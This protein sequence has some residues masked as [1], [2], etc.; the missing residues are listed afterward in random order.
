MMLLTSSCAL[1]RKHVL[2]PAEVRPALEAT[3]DQLLA[4]YNRQANAIRSVNVAVVFT[5]TTGS[6][7]SGVIEEYHEVNGFILARK[8]AQIRVIGQAPVVAKDVFDMTSDGDTFR[9]FIPSQ[10]KFIVGSTTLE[11]SAKKP[12]ENLRPQHLLDVLFWPEIPAGAPS[13]FEEWED[14]AKRFYILTALRQTAGE[15]E[16]ARKIWF[17]RTDLE[18]ARVQIFA[19]GGRVASDIRYAEWALAGEANFPR[20]IWLARPHE[21]YRLEIRITKVEVNEMIADDRFRLEQPPGTELVRAN[22]SSE[23]ARP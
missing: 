23:G 17:D 2:P 9:V 22:E 15:W 10:H 8:P 3:K 11:R 5:P 14:G 4:K 7:Y 13:V 21:D 12:I 1:S 19:T 20:H 16:I 18:V 6:A